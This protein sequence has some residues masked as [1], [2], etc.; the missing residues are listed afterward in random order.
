VNDVYEGLSWLAWF[1]TLALAYYWPVPTA[2]WLVLAATVNLLHV[3]YVAWWVGP[4]LRERV[5]AA[6]ADELALMRGQ[7]ESMDKDVADIKES[8]VRM[9]GAARGRNL[10]T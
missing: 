1:A 5:Q 4:P 6:V 10:P 8:Q 3:R 9:M 7:L 2:T